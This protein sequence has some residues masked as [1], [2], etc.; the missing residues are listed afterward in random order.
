M[1]SFEKSILFRLFNFSFLQL[2]T[3]MQENINGIL[4]SA[5]HWRWW[6]QVPRNLCYLFTEMCGVS[7]Q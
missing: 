3:N 5:Q 7:T 2:R 6:Q 1:N 4:S